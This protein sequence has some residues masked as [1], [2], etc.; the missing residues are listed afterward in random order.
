M[1]H[2]SLLSRVRKTVE[3]YGLLEGGDKVLVALSGG[4]DSVCLLFILLELKGEFALSFHIAHLNHSLRG[5]ESD[6]DAEWVK[7]LAEKLEIPITLKK[8]DVRGWVRSKRVSLEEGAREARYE[9]LSKVADKIGA[10]KIAVGHTLDDQ[11]ETVFL[12]LLRG[13]GLPGIGGIPP[14]RGRFIRPLI[15]L[16]REE[17]M[18]YL[19]AKG[20]SYR[21]DSSNLRP[22]YLRNRLRLW[23]IPLLKSKYSPRIVEL[24]GRYAEL[25]RIDNSYLETVAMGA[26]SSVLSHSSP[27]QVVLDRK[28]LK[29]LHP[30]LARRVIRIA[31]KQ[32]KGS[33]RG[34]RAE[35]ILSALELQTGKKLCLPSGTVVERE[36]DS[37]IFSSREDQ[38]EDY[39]YTLPIPGNL[40]VRE[41]KMRLVTEF[42]DKGFLP[43]DFK[44]VVP[45]EAY[46]DFDCLHPPLVVRNRRPGDRIQPFGMRGQKK[47][48]EVLIDD[49]IPRSMR[50]RIPLLVDTEGILWI[51]GNRR[52]GRAKITVDTKSVLRVRSTREDR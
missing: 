31:V 7:A 32:I 19:S 29:E 5:A 11:A 6:E 41:A 13:T 2:K 49:K 30:S 44:S 37:L 40:V 36:Y 39:I 23:L 43:K 4:P 9:F 14:K 25:A 18:E 8:L 51:I 34:I 48:K 12:R 1:K 33:L 35:H 17:I 47:L 20:L 38:C 16:T 26:F 50:E 3:K 28:R 27:T 24:L 45:D 21:E 22:D 52:C 10:T 46:F 15:G 42:V